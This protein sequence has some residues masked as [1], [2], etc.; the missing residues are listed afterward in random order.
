MSSPGP[1]APIVLRFRRDLRLADN[2]AVAAAACAG[3][4]VISLYVLDES[5][6]VRPPGGAGRWWLDKSLRALGR[7]LD[8]KGSRLMLARGPLAEAVQDLVRRAGAAE[9]V[10]SRIPEPAAA[11]AEAAMT[12]GLEGLGVT[13]RSFN[14][15]LLHEPGDVL[16]G[17]GRPYQVFTAYWRAAR[18]RLDLPRAHPEPRRLESPEH[19]PRS[20]VLEDWALHPHSPDWSQGFSVWRPGETGGQAALETFIGERL[21]DYAQRRDRLDLDG[22]SRLSPHLRWGELG[23]A[24]VARAVMAAVHAGEAGGGAGEK[25]LAE[26]GW[27]DFAADLLAQHPAMPSRNLRPEFDRMAWR[28]A[29]AQLHAWRKG[30]TGYPVIDA[31]MRQL[32]ATGF[33]PNR[34][35]MIVASFLTKDLLIDWRQGEAWFWDCLVDADLAS[36]TMNWQWSAGSGVDAQPFF[37]IFNPAAQA[38]KFDPEGTYARRW[39]PAHPPAPIVEHRMAR[40]RALEAYRLARRA[41]A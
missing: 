2:P 28:L 38:E 13:V 12:R 4:P 18:P 26:L 30:E 10:F 29:P 11:A 27:R 36:N 20:E 8:A 35:R 6:G 41:I 1:A 40:E 14:A 24:Q 39:R 17:E 5:Q 3:R 34:A 32:R 23:P 19:W 31:A 22:G 9:V 25:F 15:A 16:N 33:M 37:R 7:S 21:A